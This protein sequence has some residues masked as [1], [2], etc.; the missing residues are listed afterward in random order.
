MKYLFLFVALT[1]SLAV[2]QAVSKRNTDLNRK[3]TIDL[4]HQ[5]AE[6]LS[7]LAAADR[8]LG[9][10]ITDQPDLAESMLTRP[11]DESDGDIETLLTMACPC[12]FEIK[13]GKKVRTG[14]YAFP[15]VFFQPPAGNSRIS[16]RLST[17]TVSWTGD[18][19]AVKQVPQ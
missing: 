13:H 6:Y 11:R 8:F 16:V 12:A 15:V 9:A 14:I 18:L 19:W 4:L 7:A 3:K 10:W 5:D 1:G 2:G 17:I